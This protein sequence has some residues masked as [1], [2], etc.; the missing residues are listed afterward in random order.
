MVDQ[1]DTV[2][3]GIEQTM[4]DFFRKIKEV[5]QTRIHKYI[6]VQFSDTGA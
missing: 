2:L 3:Q 5:E 4:S 6:L 1:S